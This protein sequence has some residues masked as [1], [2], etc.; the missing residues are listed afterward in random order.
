MVTQVNGSVARA[1]RGLV[2][3]AVCAVGTGCGDEPVLTPAGVGGNAGTAATS[4]DGNDG[5]LAGSTSSGGTG[6]GGS[7]SGGSSNGGTT[8][9]GSSNGG[10]NSGGSASGSVDCGG[11]LVAT[12]SGEVPPRP[13]GQSTV[14]IN[15]CWNLMFYESEGM[16][17]LSSRLSSDSPDVKRSITVQFQVAAVAGDADPFTLTQEEKGPVTQHFGPEC[18]MFGDRQVM[19]AELTDP[20]EQLGL[21]EGSWRNVDCMDA[22]DG[23]CD[24]AM[25]YWAVG[26]GTGTWQLEDDRLLL[27]REIYVADTNE[28]VTTTSTPI[29]Y[30]VADDKLRF[31]E[32]I[33]DV[34]VAVANAPLTRVD[35][36]D[37]VQ[38]PREEGI[39]CGFVCGIAC[40]QAQ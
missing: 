35:C 34:W 7:P 33:N 24:C 10:D 17:S 19:C 32:A 12:W 15:S 38:G 36:T 16:L 8:N 4:N 28:F 1:G 18:M 6:S 37:G 20:L 9:G 25:D 5:G 14:P 13:P 39:D 21:G 23:G 31:G 11:D 30:C 22:A 40:P 29:D 27:T 3:V 26:G 2:L